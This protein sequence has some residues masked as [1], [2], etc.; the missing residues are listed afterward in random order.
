MHLNEA[1]WLGEL[2]TV[3]SEVEHNL[4]KASLVAEDS[5]EEKGVGLVKLKLEMDTTLFGRKLDDFE[6]VRDNFYE[7]DVLIIQNKGRC[8]HLGQVKK[9]VH[10]TLDLS[11]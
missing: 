6:S 7:V 2:Q 10:E 8:L 1:L 5:P 4:Y 9:V 11:S 3:A